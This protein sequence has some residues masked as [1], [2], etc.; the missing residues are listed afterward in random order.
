MACPASPALRP[1]AT[2]LELIG[3]G[4]GVHSSLEVR[5][6][7]APGRHTIRAS[8]FDEGS[9]AEGPTRPHYAGAGRRRGPR[10]RNSR[11]HCLDGNQP[12]PML[13]A[14]PALRQH[15]VVGQIWQ[16][17]D[18]PPVFGSRAGHPSASM[19]ATIEPGR[20]ARHRRHVADDAHFFNDKGTRRKPDW[21][22]AESGR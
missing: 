5:C 20:R 11:P 13:A 7:R 1:S 14:Q 10:I 15:M 19:V 3:T 21:R 9:A 17:T 18:G 6:S 16:G 12:P 8:G 22:T 2:I 4:C